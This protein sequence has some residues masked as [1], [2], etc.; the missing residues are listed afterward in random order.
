MVQL[1]ALQAWL[2]KND[3]KYP[4]R[5]SSDEE[6]TKHANFIKKMRQAQQ[7]NELSALR[8]QR[9][10]TLP[11]WQWQQTQC[12]K[13]FSD[14]CPKCKQN[15]QFDKANTP[16]LNNEHDDGEGGK[17][18][19]RGAVV[20]GKI[21]A[22]VPKTDEKRCFKCTLMKARPEYHEDQWNKTGKNANRRTCKTCE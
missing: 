20:D 8:K 16:D 19:F 5:R 12:E 1:T 6:E 21:Q 22:N 9:L 17:C 10:E 18:R 7:R 11:H 15:I 13:R 4:K 3:D 14:V 2:S